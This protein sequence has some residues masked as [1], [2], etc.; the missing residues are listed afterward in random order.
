MSQKT[1]N[2]EP[3]ETDY[4]EDKD[5]PEEEQQAETGEI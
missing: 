4:D 2:E 5:Q 1:N 3:K